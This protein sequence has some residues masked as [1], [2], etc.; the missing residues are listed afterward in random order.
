MRTQRQRLF[1]QR[2]IGAPGVRD[3]RIGISA[4]PWLDAGIEIHR[5]LGPAELDQRDRRHVHRHVE[6]EVAAADVRIELAPEVVAR[7]HHFHELDAVF[8]GFLFAAIVGSDDGDAFFRDSDVSQ[9][10]RQRALAD[11]AEPYEDD[12]SRKL[13]VNL[14]VHHLPVQFRARG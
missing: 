2:V 3:G 10:Q 5:A 8:L 14:F 11:A 7:Q 4:R 13:D 1:A 9:D 6:H 12:A